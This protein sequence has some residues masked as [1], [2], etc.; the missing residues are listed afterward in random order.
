MTTPIPPRIALPDAVETGLGTLHFPD[1]GSIEP[2]L[3][4]STTKS[5][6][7]WSAELNG[8]FNSGPTA[9]FDSA[10]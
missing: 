3:K 1:G 9:V 2:T 6:L 4:R 7:F 5:G 8:R 10:P